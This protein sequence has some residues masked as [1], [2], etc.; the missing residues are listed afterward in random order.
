LKKLKQIMAARTTSLTIGTSHENRENL[1]PKWYEETILDY[2]N[3]RLGQQEVHA[4]ILDDMPGALWTGI[5]L[6]DTRVSGRNSSE[7]TKE[8]WVET[9]KLRLARIVVAMD[10]AATSDLS[11]AEHGI[12]VAGI[13]RNKEGFVLEDLSERCTPERAARICVDAYDRWSADKVIGEVNNGGDWIGTTIQQTAKQMK[14]EGKRDSAEVNYGKVHA[15]RGKRT[16]AEPISG[17]YE[18]KR[19]HHV[20]LF[21]ELEDQMTNWDPLASGPSPDRMDADVWALTELMIGSGKGKAGVLF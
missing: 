6:E 3:T 4:K 1:D 18:Q 8:A 15:S 2:E 11:S 17:L 7:M 16:R 13:D 10:P 12:V 5:L 21:P 19:V 9:W 20:G 14:V